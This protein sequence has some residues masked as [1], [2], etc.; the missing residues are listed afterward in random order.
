ME[1][2]AIVAAVLGTIFGALWLFMWATSAGDCRSGSDDRR[3]CLR[4]AWLTPVWPFVG[5]FLLVRL[6]VE[7]LPRLFREAWPAKPKPQEAEPR[8]VKREKRKSGTWENPER[9]R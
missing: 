9:A 8:R 2:I 1:V 3:H 7:H 4:M 5:A 6:A